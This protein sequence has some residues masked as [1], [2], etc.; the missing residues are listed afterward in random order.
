MMM[1]SLWLIILTSSCAAPKVAE[2]GWTD[3]GTGYAVTYEAGRVA[4]ETKAENKLLKKE[5]ADDPTLWQS[6]THNVTVFGIGAGF[7]FVTGV[8]ILP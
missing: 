1:A 2:K 8:V 6:I 7:G 5:V 4:A 3:T